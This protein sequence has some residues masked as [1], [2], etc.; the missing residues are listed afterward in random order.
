[1]GTDAPQDGPGDAK[2]AGYS[3]VALDGAFIRIDGV[4]RTFIGWRGLETDE[5]HPLPADGRPPQRL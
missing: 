4:A 3:Y 5:A 2:R 1:V